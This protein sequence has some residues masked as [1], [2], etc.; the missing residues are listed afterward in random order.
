[1]TAL[2]IVNGAPCLSFQDSG[3]HSRADRID[4]IFH[5]QAVVFLNLVARVGSEWF[6]D[7]IV[8]SDL[9]GV[10]ARPP[11]FSL[12]RKSSGLGLFTE[13]SPTH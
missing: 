12:S 4:I 5:V 8:I 7:E 9:L 2:M 13:S 6:L 3:P 10:R 1:M 11:Y